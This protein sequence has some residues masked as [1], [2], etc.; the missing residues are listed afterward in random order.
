MIGPWGRAG[1]GSLGA[2]G[3]PM[4]LRAL[5]RVSGSLA[6]ATVLAAGCAD[7]NLV[8]GPTPAGVT[9]GPTSSVPSPGGSG[10]AGSSGAAGS[11]T[12]DGAGAASAGA[13]AAVVT[14]VEI[15]VRNSAGGCWQVLAPGAPAGV[16]RQDLWYADAGT[17]DGPGW[18][19]ALRVFASP[20]A[21]QA[22]PPV[23]TTGSSSYQ[24]AGVL[25][26][27]ASGAPP[28]VRSVVLALPG[29]VPRPTRQ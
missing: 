5:V 22:A 29:L 4:L 16:T 1:G 6:L 9:T 23:T 11:S 25:V 26:V 27:L 7:N 15:A 21:L 24:K 20:S 18:A 17:C 10:N 19:V 12:T 13:N 14:G 8:S 2:Y 28:S 3:E